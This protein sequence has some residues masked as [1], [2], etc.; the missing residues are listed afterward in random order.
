MRG[1][2]GGRTRTAPSRT[3]PQRVVYCTSSASGTTRKTAGVR[4]CQSIRPPTPRPPNPLPSPP[5]CVTL[6]DVGV[7]HPRDLDDD[8]DDVPRDHVLRNR[9]KDNL[10]P[11]ELHDDRD[12]HAGPSDGD[13]GLAQTFHVGRVGEGT[14]G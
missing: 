1:T 3:T 7:R 12:D 13:D 10:G 14:V 9:Q 6:W 4:Y 5:G 11:L 2:S 8:R